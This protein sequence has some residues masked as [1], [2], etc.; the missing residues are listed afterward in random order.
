MVIPFTSLKRPK[1]MPFAF[2]LA[3]QLQSLGLVPLGLVEACLGVAHRD[4]WA[5]VSDAGGRRPRQRVGPFGSRECC[6][7][8]R[9]FFFVGQRLVEYIYIYILYLFTYLYIYIHIV[10]LQALNPSFNV[11]RSPQNGYLMRSQ[12]KTNNL[13]GL[14]FF[15][16]HSFVYVSKPVTPQNGG[17]TSR[18]EKGSLE[19]QSLVW[20]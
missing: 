1:T 4:R 2:T 3:Y 5:P 12:T 19:N 13:R 20:P 14:L 15:E 18:G 7:C 17:L 8:H 6:F 11:G 16:N 10:P 9:E